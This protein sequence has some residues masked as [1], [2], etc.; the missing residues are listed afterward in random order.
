MMRSEGWSP[1]P[2]KVEIEKRIPV[3]A[4]LGGGHDE[5]EASKGPWWGWSDTK[6]AFEWLFWTGR[7]TSWIPLAIAALG[8]NLL[9]GYNG[10]IS[11]GHG[12]LFGIGQGKIGFMAEEHGVGL[13]YMRTIKRALDP[14]NIMNPGKILPI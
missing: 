2:L 7:I 8:L 3:Q 14:E 1:P 10:Q 12:A 13:D 5:R 6:R 4:G 9:T 11:V